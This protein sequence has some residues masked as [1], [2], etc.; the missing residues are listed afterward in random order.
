MVSANRAVQVVKLLVP[1]FR[2]L[3]VKN[4]LKYGTSEALR[5]TG[6]PTLASL[7]FQ[8]SKGNKWDLLKHQGLPDT[9]AIIK[10]SITSEIHIKHVSQK[11]MNLSS[12]G[13]PNI[14]CGCCLSSVNE[15]KNRKKT[16][17]KH[18][19]LKAKTSMPLEP[20]YHGLGGLGKLNTGDFNFSQLFPFQPPN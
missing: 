12:V 5:R 15:L 3:D 17:N 19:M 4:H 2:F 16:C 8:S 20:I 13:I 14:H 18:L 10:T 1:L 11:D 7:N 9:A 6:L